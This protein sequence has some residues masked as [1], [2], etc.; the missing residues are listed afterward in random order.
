MKALFVQIP[1]GYDPNVVESLGQE[2]STICEN[3][4]GE[5]IQVLIIPHDVKLLNEEDIRHLVKT[6]SELV[7]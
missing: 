4:L 3:M 1:T 2:L 5:K 6:L 7:K